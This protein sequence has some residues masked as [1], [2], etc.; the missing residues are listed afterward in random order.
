M[1]VIVFIYVIRKHF[2]KGFKPVCYH[3]NKIIVN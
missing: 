1:S 2:Q 3:K